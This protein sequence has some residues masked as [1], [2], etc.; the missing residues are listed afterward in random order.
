MKCRPSLLAASVVAVI[1]LASLPAQSVR[2]SDGKLYFTRP[3]SLVKASTTQ[4]AALVWGATYYFVLNIPENAGEPLGSVAISPDPSP[5]PVTFDL[6]RTYA[7]EGT[8]DRDEAR[9]SLESVTE[10]PKTGV[11]TVT[12]NPPVPPGKTVTIALSPNQ[13]PLGGVY[14]YGV[15]AF[16]AGDNPYGQF[17]GYGRIQIYD[18]GGLGSFW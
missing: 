12:F 14:L 6:D 2:L 1:S 5:D 18:R 3:P 13:N 7:F 16:P 8:R 10:A 11:I 9:L 15:T 17:L 4:N